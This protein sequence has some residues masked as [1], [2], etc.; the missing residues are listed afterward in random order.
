MAV[1][2][3]RA[4]VLATASAPQQ[5]PALQHSGGVPVRGGVACGALLPAAGQG[6][7]THSARGGR[8]GHLR[9]QVSGQ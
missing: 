8:A 6:D 7:P 1:R 3:H 5:G 9:H 2:L 4:P